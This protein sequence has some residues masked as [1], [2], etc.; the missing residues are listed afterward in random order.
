M[1][2]IIGCAETARF[3]CFIDNLAQLFTL[4]NIDVLL[5]MVPP[6]SIEWCYNGNN[7]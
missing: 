3:I 4:Q 5:N 2:P 7:S 1:K 6:L